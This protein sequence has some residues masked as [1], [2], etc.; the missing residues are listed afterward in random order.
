MKQ[1]VKEVIKWVLIFAVALVLQRLFSGSSILYLSAIWLILFNIFIAFY[2]IYLLKKDG[3]SEI[4]V[5]LAISIAMQV[6][7]NLIKI[8]NSNV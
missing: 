1:I 3:V 6:I 5:I 8:M 7:P 2:I 4:K